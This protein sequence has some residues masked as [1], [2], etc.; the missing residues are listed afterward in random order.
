[1]DLAQI[2][3]H[4]AFLYGSEASEAIAEQ[5]SSIL[6]KFHQPVQLGC[7]VETE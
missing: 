6:E 3:N 1:M 4:L 5:L 2:H 7:G